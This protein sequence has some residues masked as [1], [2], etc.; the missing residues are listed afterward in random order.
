MFPFTLLMPSLCFSLFSRKVLQGKKEYRAWHH[1]LYSLLVLLF[2]QHHHELRE[3]W[4]K[5]IRIINS[6]EERK[7]GRDRLSRDEIKR[8]RLD[9]VEI[10]RKEG[11]RHVSLDMNLTKIP[12]RKEGEGRKC[13]VRLHRTRHERD[14]T[15]DRYER[16]RK[17]LRAE[18]DGK[19][20]YSWMR[21]MMMM[22]GRI[23][24]IREEERGW[25]GLV[26]SYPSSFLSLFS[27]KM[28]KNLSLSH[29]WVHNTHNNQSGLSFL[30]Q[31]HDDD[32]CSCVYFAFIP[33]SLPLSLCLSDSALY[34][35][36][37]CIV[38]DSLSLPT[39]E[40]LADAVTFR[41]KRLLCNPIHGVC[42]QS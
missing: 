39:I 3:R 18:D 37:P 4:Q 14:S 24:R 17:K 8:D 35:S 33:N 7:K 10:R 30:P 31:D 38:F 32:R 2:N 22:Q 23:L 11:K 42:L 1:V 36:F 34:L 15:E 41:Q 40:S 13:C 29:L 21:V 5:V 9:S 12:D 20:E 16:E 25:M 19:E 6:E 26:S 27:L 28:S